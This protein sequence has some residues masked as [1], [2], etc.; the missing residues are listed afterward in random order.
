MP[1]AKKPVARFVVVSNYVRNCTFLC[2]DIRKR[3]NYYHLKA[4][5]CTV[6]PL[7]T[8]TLRGMQKWPSYRGGRLM[9]ISISQQ[10]S[11]E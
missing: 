9:E 4:F 5:K 8:A 10:L 1:A 3:E 7:K 6:K 11:Q 2:L